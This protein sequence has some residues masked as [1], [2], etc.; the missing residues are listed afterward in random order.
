MKNNLNI[1]FST[2]KTP[3]DLQKWIKKNIT[4]YGDYN[5]VKETIIKSPEQLLIDKRGMC[6]ELVEFERKFMDIKNISYKRVFE[7]G[8]DDEDN[9]WPAHTYLYYKDNN[10]YVW[11]ESARLE[12]F[13]SEKSLINKALLQFKQE[14]PEY[15]KFSYYY[16][17]FNVTPD[18]TIYD[19]IMAAAYNNKGSK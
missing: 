1:L 17:N 11:F 10:K 14:N 6:F 4:Y 8:K 2:L 3:L 9:V 15:N 19:Y 7:C 18:M 12:Y 5:N 13:N 16:I